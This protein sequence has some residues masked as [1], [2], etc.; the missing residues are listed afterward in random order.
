MATFEAQQRAAGVLIPGEGSHAPLKLKVAATSIPIAT[1]SGGAVPSNDAVQVGLLGNVED[2]SDLTGLR[3]GKLAHIDLHD[4]S[5]GDEN[6]EDRKRRVKKDLPDDVEELFE[7]IPKWQ[8]LD[9][10]SHLPWQLYTYWKLN[11]RSLSFNSDP[12]RNR[13]QTTAGQG[14]CR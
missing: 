14:H 12:G 10:A 1:N 8:H 3:R 2:E 4:T 5:T 11:I 7:K 6:R 9:E 13:L